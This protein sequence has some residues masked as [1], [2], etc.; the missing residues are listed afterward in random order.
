MMGVAS[1]V[2]ANPDY[3]DFPSKD[4]DFTYAVAPGEDGEVEFG[5]D[6]YVVSHIQF[7]NTS[8]KTGKVTWDFGD[9][10][11]STENNPVHKYGEAGIYQVKL[12]VEGVGSR[13]YPLMIY[14]IAPV[15]SI[16]EQ[17]AETLV[18]NDVEVDFDIFLPN[19]ENKKVKYEW[20][21]P[22]GALDADGN[23]LTTFVG[24]ADENGNV[25]Y[26]GKV[27]FKNIG[28]QKIVLKSTFDFGGA[29][30]R[31]LQ[32]SYVN[33]QVGADKEYK[34][35]YY[36]AVDGNIKALKL[37]PDSELPAGTKNQP[38]DMGVGSGTMPFNLVSY[39]DA[40]GNSWIYILDAGKQYTYTATGGEATDQG[41][42]GKINVMSADGKYVNVFT[43]NIGRKAYSDP[44]FGCVDG[45]MLL[46]S[47][48]NSGL[49][50]TPLKTRGATE[51]DDFFLLDQNLGYYNKGIA[52]GAI[53]STILKDSKKMYW[54]GKFYQAK[55]IFRFKESD[56]VDDGASASKPY[57]I[58]LSGVRLKAFNIDEQRGKLYV[59]RWEDGDGF[60]VYP[61]PADN[62]TVDKAGFT[63]SFPMM[64]D[65]M[66]SSADEQ[67]H[68]TQIALDSETGNAYFGFN[69]NVADASK[70]PTGLKCYDAATETV[71]NIDVCPEKIL[72]VT[73]NDKKS[74][75]F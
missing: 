48:R 37:I 28:S 39:N 59:W 66:N 32:E 21:F 34:T 14:D 45:D 38:F 26:P 54:W 70:Y 74:K 46:Y 24:Y 51:P 56:I 50:R 27:H 2:E 36:A 42:D 47:D 63:K 60:Y 1:C 52:W 19:P 31:T 16:K 22:D 20:I 49:R 43:T 33:V 58:V 61:L 62:A 10:T 9:G 29:E 57:E 72:G 8:F 18:I 30:E 11:T 6:F 15:L 25:D 75:L 71:V 23:P 35:L 64:A 41:G 4:V 55:G 5:I 13:T 3:Q 40:D 73:I 65:P 44:F 68:C 12:T 53:G 17:T 7:T 69:K 67:I